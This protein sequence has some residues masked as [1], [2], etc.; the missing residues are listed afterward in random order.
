MGIYDRGY[1]N[2]DE[3]KGPDARRA[4]GG[5][6][7]SMVMVIIVINVVVYLLDMFS[8]AV[9]LPD[10]TPSEN[11]MN[12]S[13][14]LALKQGAAAGYRDKL[15]ENPEWPAEIREKLEAAES[16]ARGPLDSPLYFY[17]LISYGFAH[18]PVISER[19]IWH[20]AFNMVALFFLGRPV[21]Q[22]Y[23]GQEFIRFYLLAI[24]VS[25]L[26]WMLSYALTNRAGV[27][28]GA[29]GGVAAVVMLFV[30]NYPREQILLMGIIPMPAWVLGVLLVGMDA[31]NSL[32]PDSGIAVE[33][34]LGG[35]AFAA[36]YYFG[37]WNFQWLRFDG[38]SKRLARKPNL[39]VHDPGKPREELSNE[40]DQ[41]LDKL[42]REGESS[43]TKRERKILEKYSRQVRDRRDP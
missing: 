22:R 27:A 36:A 10:G 12:L 9:I 7:R 1:Y 23:G 6:T 26:V 25:G 8:G 42:H 16:A 29:S 31:L 35:A 4:V 32:N 15:D 21:E 14:F 30:F 39:K 33:A 5:G 11:S 38:L 19:S 34:H 2:D 40:A 28:V 24:V 17:Q 37:K 41:V 13:T 18:A 3:W 43:L 20:I